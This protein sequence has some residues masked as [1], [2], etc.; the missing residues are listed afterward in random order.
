MPLASA[1][2]RARAA[3][4]G[5]RLTHSTCALPLLDCQWI[6]P[7]PQ[8]HVP[9]D[10]FTVMR[11]LPPTMLTGEPL[12]ATLDVKV[13]MQLDSS[14]QRYKVLPQLSAV[15]GLTHGTRTEIVQAVWA[16]VKLHGLQDRDDRRRIRN[17]GPLGQVRRRPCFSTYSR[18]PLPP[19]GV[20]WRSPRLAQTDP[21]AARLRDGSS[22]RPRRSSRSITFPSS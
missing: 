5:A 15:I 8:A 17:E 22:S 21:S 10:G 12:P 16:Y 2:S 9:Q 18:E 4:S 6:R 3:P 1:L 7:P 13:H 19:P 20:R 14:P 11:P